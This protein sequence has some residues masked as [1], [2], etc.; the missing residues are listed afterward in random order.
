MIHELPHF[1]VHL[2]IFLILILFW[3]TEIE[4]VNISQCGCTQSLHLKDQK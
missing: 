1:C 3:N 2:N 4:K